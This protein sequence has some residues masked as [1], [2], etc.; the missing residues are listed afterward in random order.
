MLTHGFAAVSTDVPSANKENLLIKALKEKAEPGTPQKAPRPTAAPTASPAPPAK[1][2]FSS[3]MA[4]LLGGAKKSTSTDTNKNLQKPILYSAALAVVLLAMGYVSRGQG[5]L[6]GDNADTSF[7]P[8]PVTAPAKP[9]P[10]A[11]ATESKLV[12]PAKHISSTEADANAAETDAANVEDS[13]N[14]ENGDA[15]SAS[16]TPKNLPPSGND[17]AGTGQGAHNAQPTSAEKVASGIPKAQLAPR[18]NSEPLDDSSSSDN[19]ANEPQPSSHRH[20]RHW[21]IAAQE[22]SPRRHKHRAPDPEPEIK[23]H[24]R[25][26]IAKAHKVHV[27]APTTIKLYDES[28]NPLRS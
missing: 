21:T 19:N 23:H 9:K 5:S 12:T 16:S 28:G 18:Q 7:P 26:S 22:P 20:K 1:T 11:V 14:K 6:L 15:T 13:V 27:Y 10:K 25:A 24:A 4:A 2:D 8:A 3:K 17:K